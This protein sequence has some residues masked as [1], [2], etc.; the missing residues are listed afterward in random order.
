MT[1]GKY[2]S[3]G[4]HES[5]NTEKVRTKTRIET[6]ESFDGEPPIEERLAEA[7]LLLG[8][9]TY[10]DKH[11]NGTDPHEQKQVQRL[12]RIPVEEFFA[13]ASKLIPN[14]E[15]EKQHGLATAFKEGWGKSCYC[16]ADPYLEGRYDMPTELFYELSKRLT[17]LITIGLFQDNNMAN[18]TGTTGQF[19]RK[20]NYKIENPDVYLAN[21]SPILEFINQALASQVYSAGKNQNISDRAAESVSYFCEINHNGKLEQSTSFLNKLIQNDGEK[22][23]EQAIVRAKALKKRFE[24]LPEDRNSCKQK[25]AVILPVWTDL[26][27]DCHDSTSPEFIDGSLE[28]IEQQIAFI[29]RNGEQMQNDIKSCEKRVEEAK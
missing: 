13:T 2:E 4:T 5:L 6:A 15:I 26:K 19:L 25:L 3:P 16:V 17:N 18:D 27:K 12:N 7:K 21:I 10:I 1:K 23:S 11:S 8:Q 28:L 22:I 9:K 29:E 20:T 24:S 14:K